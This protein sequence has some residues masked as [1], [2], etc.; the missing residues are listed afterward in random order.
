MSSSPSAAGDRE[1]STTMYSWGSIQGWTRIQIQNRSCH[2][3][4]Y[5]FVCEYNIQWYNT[6]SHF[7]YFLWVRSFTA[8]SVV[9]MFAP[10]LCFLLHVLILYFFFLG[11]C[12]LLPPC[13]AICIAASASSMP[14]F[15]VLKIAC[16]FWM[17]EI[18]NIWRDSNAFSE[19]ACT[20]YMHTWLY[21]TQHRSQDHWTGSR[22]VWST[23][24][25]QNVS[26]RH[27]SAVNADNYAK[28]FNA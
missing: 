8:I 19:L 16:C 9:L 17:S 1:D 5:A 13:T 7:S 26:E 6:T 4:I 25:Y 27:P 18:L 10:L 22:A 28:H 23:S 21:G 20:S 14:L 11:S 3:R 24:L 12:S 15:G 2:E